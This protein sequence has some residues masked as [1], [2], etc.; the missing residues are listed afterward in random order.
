MSRNV[1]PEIRLTN[2]DSENNHIE[3][4]LTNVSTAFANALRRVMI[5][6]VPTMSFD[7]L[8]FR[9]N[10]SPL[11]DEFIAHR[12]G[13]LPIHSDEV[14][15]LRYRDDCDCIEGCPRCRVRY[16]INVKCTD[17]TPR[18]VTTRDLEYSPEYDDDPAYQ[19]E[20]DAARTMKPVEPP[21]I[22]GGPSVPIT[23]AKLG[24]GQVLQVLCY[25]TKGIGREHAKWSPCC[26]STYRMQPKI[27]LNHAF[28]RTKTPEW[29]DNFVTTCPNNVFRHAANDDTIEIENELNCTFCR[30]CQE[31]LENE[32]DTDSEKNIFIDQVPDKYIFTVESNGSLPPQTIVIRAWEILG[33]KLERLL[34]DIKKAPLE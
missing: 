23:I 8:Y 5:S 4:E 20:L 29:L 32:G 12:I 19:I 28:F 16:V 18:L 26:C 13:L 3:F 14:D 24:K 6:E 2:L 27:T 11:P 10:T 34:Q 9:Q 22:P 1:T 7:D 33:S 15:K 25:A 17:D 31:A 30:Q 21:A